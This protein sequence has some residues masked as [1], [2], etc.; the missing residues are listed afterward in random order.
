MK[1]KIIAVIISAVLLCVPLFGCSES[2]TPGVLEGEQDTS[3]G[4]FS[5]GGSAVQYG[6][7]IYY[8]NG[9]RGYDDAGSDN[10]WGKVNK[11]GL[12]RA[13]L[14]G[15]E[16]RLV[17]YTDA[18]GVTTQV[19][20]FVSTFDVAANSD[21]VTHKATIVTGYKKDDD[22]KIVYDDDKKPVEIT[23]EIDELTSECLAPKT[24]GTAGYDK[25]GVFVFDDSVY[26][27]SPANS[28]DREGNFETEKISFYRTKL[29]GSK[30]VK[31]YTT[32]TS[33]KTAKYAFYKQGE[34]VYLVVH[35]G[36]DIVSVTVGAK[37]AEKAEIIASSVTDVLFPVKEVYYKGMDTNSAE[38]FVYFTRDI[39][40]DDSVRAGKIT[41]AIRPDGSERITLLSPGYDITLKNVD[42]GFVFFEEDRPAGKQIKFSNFHEA[43]MIHSESYKAAYEARYADIENALGANNPLIGH[44]SGTAFAQENISDYTTVI[45]V[46]PDKR[47]NQTYVICSKSSGIFSYDGEQLITI[48]DGTVSNLLAIKDGYVY[49]NNSGEFMRTSA[50]EKGEA[51]SLA[52]DMNTSATFK[53]DVFGD[54]V[55][56]FGKVDDYASDYMMIVNLT[57]IDQEK[58]FL[59]V[60]IDDDK[61]DPSVE[62]KTESDE[63]NAN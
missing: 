56:M 45:G 36:N 10:L 24:I 14:N 41:E 9:Y 59:G 27:A 7:Y 17:S 42:G 37:K 50:F 62:L 43:F 33:D 31:L 16:D 19:K 58:Q 49:F 39:S 12:Y 21:F 28:Q 54:F 48:Y 26:Y 8:I 20:T 4:V 47:S 30:S 3:Y 23:E 61:Y 25:G 1:K 53:L 51:E 46:R 29:D 32:K 6:N 5:N 18:F 35:D 13:K 38:D 34:K 60:K 55:A 2:L 52:T 15:G 44:I 63:S 11:G 40:D 22:G 57:R